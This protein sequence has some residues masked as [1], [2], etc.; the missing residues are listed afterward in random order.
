MEKEDKSGLSEGK[1][2]ADGLGALFE[3]AQCKCSW[4]CR[5]RLVAGYS[6][7]ELPITLEKFAGCCCLEEYF[8][9]GF[10]LKA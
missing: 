3:H 1:G 8:S 10:C 9:G 4:N 2:N 6:L 7:I 5:L